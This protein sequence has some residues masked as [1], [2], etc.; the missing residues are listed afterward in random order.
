LVIGRVRVQE[1]RAGFGHRI[2][3]AEHRGKVET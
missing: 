2:A 3:H 1:Q